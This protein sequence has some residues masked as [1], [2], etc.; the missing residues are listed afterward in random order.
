MKGILSFL[1]KAGLVT[2]D[3]TDAPP[4]EQA[5]ALDLGNT[6]PAPSLAHTA[7]AAPTASTN[8]S[9]ATALPAHSEGPLLQLDDIYAREGVSPSA[10]PAERLLRLLEGLNAMDAATRQLAIRAMDAAD[11]SWTI[12][13]PLADA[14]AKVTALAAHAS[15]LESG[16]GQIERDTQARLD[17][18]SARQ[19]QVV[20]EI[21]K[22]MAE[23]EALL[24][25]ETARAAEETAAHEAALQA[26]RER[27]ARELETLSQASAQLQSLSTQFGAP[28][29]AVKE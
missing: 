19:A 4:V 18:V 7:S 9:P 6:V 1:E 24:S 29:G 14:A 5:P 27:T 23:L 10:Y 12:A 2:M 3:A 13:D 26:A 15:R 8:P 11:E 20:G 21:Q 25:R 28:A 16:L 22:Q 17:A